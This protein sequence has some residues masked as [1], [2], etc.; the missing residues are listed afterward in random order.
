[1]TAK[2]ILITGASRG[3]GAAAARLLGSQ[4]HRL[5]VARS[6]D[7]LAALAEEI[8]AGPGEAIALQCDVSNAADVALAVSETVQRYGRLDVLVNN[9]G[10]IEP[11]AHIADIDPDAWSQV[12]DVNTKGVFYGLRYAI[13]PMLEQG[14]GTVI[15]ISSGA[16][17]KALEGWS[18][19][20][21]TKAAVLSLT[22]CAHV[23]YGDRGI[24]VVGMSPGT[25]ATDMQH[26]IRQFGINPVSQL[27]PDAHIPPDWAARAIAYLCTD[28]A[29][30]FAGTDF[31][32]KTDEGRARVGLPPR[33]RDS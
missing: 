21:A 1:M 17:T 20:C 32:I 2:T 29:R 22:R 27:D 7:A 24:T 16:A 10:L 28:A 23:E 4:G 12:V 9:A 3:I 11:I 5:A 26:A 13:P 15:N 18:H 19:Y 33:N 6:L 31:S 14:G 30:E 8:N 25:V